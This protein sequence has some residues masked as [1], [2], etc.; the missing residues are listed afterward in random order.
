MMIFAKIA[1]TGARASAVDYKTIPA[2]IVGAKAEFEFMDPIW[3]GL[4][5]TAVFR[6]N[7]VR[8]VPMNGSTVTV[9]AEVV[10]SKGVRLEIGVYGTDASKAVAIPTLWATA[11]YIKDSAE[12][13]E[14]SGSIGDTAAS[15]DEET[16]ELT[17]TG[18]S[19][20]ES[21]GEMMI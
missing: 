14:G 19:F 13:P 11:G 2:G 4:T 15:Y 21:T 8:S 7:C 16:G 9:P 3:D 17:I 5:K 10:A 12:P 6:G 20:D 1:V 18:I